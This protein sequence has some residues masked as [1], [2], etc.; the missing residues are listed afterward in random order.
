MVVIEFFDDSTSWHDDLRVANTGVA[1]AVGIVCGAGGIAIDE[2]S[3]CFDG[4]RE[5]ECVDEF[6][7]GVATATRNSVSDFAE[8]EAGAVDE[9]NALGF[10]ILKKIRREHV[11]ADHD[12]GFSECGVEY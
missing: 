7:F 10:E 12:G 3:I 1:C 2:C 8:P 5:A 11:P 6:F 9:L 4:A